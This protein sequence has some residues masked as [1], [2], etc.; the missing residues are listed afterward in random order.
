M[1]AQQW[2][3]W[4]P[5]PTWQT[6]AQDFHSHSDPGRRPALWIDADEL[7]RQ[8]LKTSQLWGVIVCVSL[9]NLWGG[10]KRLHTHL[11]SLDV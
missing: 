8:L 5:W 3:I 9:K 6:A 7:C 4:G 2:C 10:K 11:L 1:I